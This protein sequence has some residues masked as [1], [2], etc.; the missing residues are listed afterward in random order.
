MERAPKGTYF[1]DTWDWLNSDAVFGSVSVTVTAGATRGVGFHN[2]STAGEYLDLRWL[3]A[4]LDNAAIVRLVI[5]PNFNLAGSITN[6]TVSYVNPI[7][8]VPPCEWLAI[9]SPGTGAIN[10]H[11]TPSQLTQL[12]YPGINFGTFIRVPANWIFGCSI[13]AGA[14]N[15]VLAVSMY[16][17]FIQETDVHSGAALA[18]RSS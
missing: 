13:T 12:S 15:T 9:A 18:Q 14:S 4:T 16:G 7:E 8:G 3:F 1:R 2:I 10:V 6:P 17:Q 11:Q 5:S